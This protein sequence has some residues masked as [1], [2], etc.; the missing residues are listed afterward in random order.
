[1][2]LLLK[3]IQEISY[4]QYYDIGEVDHTNGVAKLPIQIAMQPSFYW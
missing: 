1:L 3:C 4:Y 2:L